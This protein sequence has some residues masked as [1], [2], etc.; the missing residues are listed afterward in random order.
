MKD[1]NSHAHVERDAVVETAFPVDSNFNS[2][3][4]VERDFYFVH[5]ITTFLHF[6]SHAHV[7]RDHSNFPTLHCKTISTHTLMWSVTSE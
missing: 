1:F 6:N 7:E 5:G 3:A 2:H 4:H